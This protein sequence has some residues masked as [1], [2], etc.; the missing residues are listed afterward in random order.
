VENGVGVEEG[1]P[2]VMTVSLGF[3]RTPGIYQEG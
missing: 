3:D 2:F 1:K